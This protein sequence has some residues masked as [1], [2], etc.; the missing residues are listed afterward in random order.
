HTVTITNPDGTKSETVIEDGKD[1]K[2]ATAEVKD[3]NDGTHTIT[4]TNP[5]GSQTTTVVRNG[6]KGDKG[7]PGKDGKSSYVHLV[8]GENEAGDQGQWIIT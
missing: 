3:N 7:D 8:K 1:G 2:A 5:D 4:I 6:E